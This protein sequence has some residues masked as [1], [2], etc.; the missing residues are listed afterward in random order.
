MLAIAFLHGFLVAFALILPLGPQNMFVISQ[1]TTHHHYRRTVPVVVTAA[2]SDTILIAG[3]VLGVSVVLVAA[4]LL[5]EGLTALG[6]V[7]LVWMGW[8]SWRAPVRRAISDE[9]AM[10]YWTLK[11]RILQ[12]VRASLLNP[13]AIMDTVVVIGS[14]AALYGRTT[15]RLAYALAAIL[16]SWVWFF[17]IGLLGR[18]FGQ[19]RNQEG[20]VKWINRISAGLMWTIAS[21]YLIQLGSAWWNAQS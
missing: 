16:V 14:G 12:T 13:H 7:F 11:R 3:A 8:Q 10:A 4:P 9:A 17:A 6:V 18:A 19:L 2:L 5:K 1:G 15:D 21:R 20:A